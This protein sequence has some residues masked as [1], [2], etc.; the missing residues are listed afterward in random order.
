MRSNRQ[1]LRRPLRNYII[2]RHSRLFIH[3]Y[4]NVLLLA[5]I[6]ALLLLVSTQEAKTLEV[7]FKGGDS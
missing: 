3:K 5:V 7:L 6:L 4:G 2:N 1:Q